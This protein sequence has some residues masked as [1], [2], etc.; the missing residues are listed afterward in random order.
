M[1]N[2]RFSISTPFD[3]SGCE[4][5]KK[6]PRL[7][8]TSAKRPSPRAT[9]RHRLGRDCAWVA[10]ACGRPARRAYPGHVGDRLPPLDQAAC[11]YVAER[12][13]LA[14]AEVRPAERAGDGCNWKLDAP[15][16]REE[17]RSARW[18]ETERCPA[19]ALD[20]GVSH[21]LICTPLIIASPFLGFAVTRVGRPG[22]ED[23]G[24]LAA[25]TKLKTHQARKAYNPTPRCET[26]ANIGA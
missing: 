15:M 6:L 4:M 22:R 23:Q 5:G 7:E 14:V 21:G 26:E 24:G 3:Q 19:H 1:P 13:R 9:R 10:G 16:D 17:R 12:V 2:G 8:S 18:P 11:E 20:T 25:R